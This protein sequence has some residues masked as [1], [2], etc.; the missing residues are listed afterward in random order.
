[1]E[2]GVRVEVE[3]GVEGGVKSGGVKSELGGGVRGK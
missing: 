1:M 2:G 3:G